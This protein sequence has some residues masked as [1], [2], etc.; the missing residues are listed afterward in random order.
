MERHWGL[1]FAILLVAGACSSG[2]TTDS[3]F[4]APTTS[5]PP[6]T[7]TT[8]ATTT[9]SE[10]APTEPTT[11]EAWLEDIDRLVERLPALHPNPYWRV[12]EEAFLAEVAE[13]R[14]LV[15]ELTDDEIELELVRL[16]AFIDGHSIISTSQDPLGYH[17]YQIRFFDFADGLFVVEAADSDLIGG[18]LL[19]VNG[20]DPAQALEA[21]APY[22]SHDN[23]QTI[24][25][26]AP[27]Y[28]LIPEL[29]AAVG[30][31]DRPAAPAFEIETA[32]GDV[33]LIN[34]PVLDSGDWSAWA[35]HPVLLPPRPAL[36]PEQ[37]T[38]ASIWWMHV[39]D[40]G[41][42]YVQYNFVTNLGNI[43]DELEAAVESET[44]SKIV[45]DL[46]RNPGGNNTTFGPLRTFLTEQGASGRALVVVTSRQTFSAAAN[47]A[48]YLDVDT[49]AVFV[50]E[51]MGGRPNLYGDTRA[52]FLPNSQIRAEISAR[53]WEIGGPGD[54][55]DTIDPDIPVEMTSTDYFGGLDPV[56]DAAL[57]YVPRS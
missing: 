37:Q 24:K 10:P 46:R 13:L 50:G 53:Y 41:A 7:S 4:P 51:G 15:P 5:G 54:N 38:D 52:L 36:V 14:R 18:R 21:V 55:R 57:G 16:V 56:L 43:V 2:S 6:T 20:K 40:S 25:N 39:P 31:I 23:D 47:F 49:D 8:L 3:S 30:V 19:S 32:A 35:E 9:T 1:A 22:V 45:V 33:V 34:P 28:M 42:I 48:T 44:I 12:G 27:L 11:A 26:L 29:L 17:R